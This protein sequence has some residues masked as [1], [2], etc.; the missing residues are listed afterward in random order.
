MK[1]R[2][3]KEEDKYRAEIG[4]E[5]KFGKLNWIAIENDDCDMSYSEHYYNTVEEA[6]EACKKHHTENGYDQ[7]GK[8]II[9]E[10]EL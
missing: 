4:K 6:V 5:N 10:F 8:D 3:R 7:I 9:K 1:Y 2:V